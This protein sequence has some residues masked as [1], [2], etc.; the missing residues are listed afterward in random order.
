[1]ARPPLL[2]K[3]GN[4]LTPPLTTAVTNRSMRESFPERA[5]MKRIRQPDQDFAYQVKEEPR[6]DYPDS[7]SNKLHQAPERAPLRRR[8][9]RKL[10]EARSA[11]DPV[12]VFGNAFAAEKSAALRTT[13]C[14]CCAKRIR[15]T[16]CRGR[17]PTKIRH[18]AGNSQ[19]FSRAKRSRILWSCGAR[20]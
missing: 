11:E 4:A 9:P 6:D 17:A 20:T 5:L 12:V 14:R 15:S 13:R 3:E 2:C 10:P 19:T 16:S 18:A 8:R 1:M 7:T